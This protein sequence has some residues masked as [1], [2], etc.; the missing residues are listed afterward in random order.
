MNLEPLIQHIVQLITAEPETVNV[1]AKR[2]REGLTYYIRVAP[3]DV[4]KVIGKSGRVI[5]SLRYFVSAAASKH[6][7][8]AFVKV[9]TE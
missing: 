8:R 5:S 1:T 2:E 9:V 7:L 3:N 4:G 6:R